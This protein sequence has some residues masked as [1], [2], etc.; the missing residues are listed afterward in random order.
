[1]TEL[2]KAI[3]EL[4]KAQQLLRSIEAG[5]KL[6]EQQLR[7]AQQNYAKASTKYVNLKL[8]SNKDKEDKDD[9]EQE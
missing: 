9:G 3:D 8:K 4:D 2:E 7:R 1:M 6:K 5:M